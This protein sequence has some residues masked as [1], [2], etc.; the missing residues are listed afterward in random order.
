[1]IKE[2]R[3]NELSTESNDVSGMIKYCKYFMSNLSELWINAGIDLKQRLQK[4]I[5]PEGILLD[6]KKV[7]TTVTNII[8]GCLHDINTQNYNLVSRRGVEPLLQE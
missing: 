3:I 2:I 7:R 1:M 4:L 6:G 8:F 5:F